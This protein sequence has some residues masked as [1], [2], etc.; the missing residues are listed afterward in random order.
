MSVLLRKYKLPAIGAVM[1]CV[2]G[3][4]YYKFVGCSS[5]QC[6]ITSSPVNSSIYGAV[7]FAVAF[8]M[9]EKQ[10]AKEHEKKENN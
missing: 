2:A 8:S 10:D 1:G 6:M 5:G 9:F 4:L 3:F 7:M